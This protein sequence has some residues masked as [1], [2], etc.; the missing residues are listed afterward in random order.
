[1]TESKHTPGPWRVD[2]EF[3]FADGVRIADTTANED[4]A[5]PR[6]DGQC[7]ADARLIAAAPD[8]L[9]ALPDLLDA[10][11]VAEQVMHDNLGPD[12]PKQ[13]KAI[14]RARVAICLVTGQ[15]PL[16]YGH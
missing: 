10:L 3:V 16:T 6:S 2:G 11:I 4:D 14:S 8:L 7:D 13:S 15:N 9:D 1:M 5:V 12:M